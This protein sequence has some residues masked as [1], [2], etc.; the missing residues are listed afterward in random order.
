MIQAGSG[1]SH[2]ERIVKGTEMFQIWFDP[3]F[4]KTLRESATYKDYAKESFKSISSE[5]KEALFYVGEN[6]DNIF[7][8]EGLEIQKTLYNSGVFEEE[9]DPAFT[10]SYYLL[11]GELQLG[12]DTLVKADYY[13]L[14]GTKV[15]YL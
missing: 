11:A 3:D 10:Y 15:G 13:V 5:N 1:V 7:I 2:S 6:G 12:R 14:E 4:S 9:L 8:T